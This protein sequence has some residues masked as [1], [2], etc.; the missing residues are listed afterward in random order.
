MSLEPMSE[1]R[2]PSPGVAVFRLRFLTTFSTADIRTWAKR[3]GLAVG[4]RGRLSP[5]IVPAYNDAHSATASAASVGRARTEEPDN[6]APRRT[7][8]RQAALGLGPARGRGD[9]LRR[10]GPG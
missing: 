8:R 5:D 6:A 2:L 3:T 10:D 1:G 4:D 9:G 7:V